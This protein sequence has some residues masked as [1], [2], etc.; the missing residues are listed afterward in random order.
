M[1]K[2]V[3]FISFNTSAMVAGVFVELLL[4]IR[5]HIFSS[6]EDRTTETDEAAIAAEPIQGWSAKPR[7][8]N[9]PTPTKAGSD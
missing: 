4:C 1:L 6:K 8:M 9:T 3:S 5:T 2:L 7:G